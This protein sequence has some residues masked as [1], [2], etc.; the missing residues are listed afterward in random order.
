MTSIHS[1]FDRFQQFTHP[2]NENCLSGVFDSRFPIPETYQS[3]MLYAEDVGGPGQAPTVF[4]YGTVC[5]TVL[6]SLHCSY[7]T[8]L[9]ATSLL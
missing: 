8:I 3:R 7:P 9:S 2:I 4:L 5:T 6:Y 1:F